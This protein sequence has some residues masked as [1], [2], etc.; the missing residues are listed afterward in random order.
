M[1]LFKRSTPDK[2]VY[3]FDKKQI[4]QEIMHKGQSAFPEWKFLHFPNGDPTDILV[5]VPVTRTVHMKVKSMM[6]FEKEEEQTFQ[7][8]IVMDVIDYQ[9]HL[10]PEHIAFWEKHCFKH[11]G[12]SDTISGLQRLKECYEVL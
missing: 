8:L 9:E 2:P 11:Y 12:T 6:A 4:I 10:S 7:N 5:I 3:K 1:S